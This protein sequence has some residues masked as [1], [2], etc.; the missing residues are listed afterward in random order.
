MNTC[1]EAGDLQAALVTAR[2]AMAQAVRL[3]AAEP[4]P[5]QAAVGVLAQLDEVRRHVELMTVVAVE[6]IDRSGAFADDGSKSTK[7][8]ARRAG[9]RRPDA[10]HPPGM[11]R[12]EHRRRACRRHPQRHQRC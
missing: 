7:A 4:L 12:R 2:Q 1:F 5:G 6:R 8:G 11:G 3:A 10:G 9:A